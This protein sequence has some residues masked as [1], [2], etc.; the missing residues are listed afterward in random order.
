MK[1]LLRV[2]LDNIHECGHFIRRRGGKLSRKDIEEIRKSDLTVDEMSVLMG[3]SRRAI[4]KVKNNGESK[5]N[6]SA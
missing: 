5:S 1:H 2:Y 4:L 6:N 3:R